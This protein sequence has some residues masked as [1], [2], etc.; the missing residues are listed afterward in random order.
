[1]PT[2]KVT[3]PSNG[4]TLRLTGDSPPTEQELE[5]VFSQ[6]QQNQPASNKVNK[7]LNTFADTS[8]G[9]LTSVLGYLGQKSAGAPGAGIGTAMGSLV[10]SGMQEQVDRFQDSNRSGL[11]KGF[12]AT[13]WLYNLALNPTGI[14]SK[15]GRDLGSSDNTG[16]AVKDAGIA[17]ATAFILSAILTPKHNANKT[18]E[19]F[20]NK[21]GEKVVDG[22]KVVEV[23]QEQFDKMPAAKKTKAVKVAFEATINELKDKTIP[24]EEAMAM[25]RQYFSPNFSLTTGNPLKGTAIDKIL[26]TAGQGM[27]SQTRPLSS[28]AAIADDVYSAMARMQQGLKFPTKIA[29]G[30]ALNELLRKAMGR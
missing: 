8:K 13:Q 16:K 14:P 28:G 29:G 30:M 1:M 3:D 7:A 20:V 27:R 24:F 9:A 5:Q 26:K 17:G 11:E 18:R 25:K 4:K 6:Y 15:L 21:N 2:Y 22:N 10:G 12:D 23:V 19:F